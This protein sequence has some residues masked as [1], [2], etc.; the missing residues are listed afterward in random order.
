MLYESDFIF[1]RNGKFLGEQLCSRD[2]VA[3][4]KSGKLNKNI[5]STNC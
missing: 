2:H 4:E 3:I 1:G 5:G